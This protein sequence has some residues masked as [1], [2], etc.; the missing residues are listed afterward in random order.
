MHHVRDVDRS[1][2]PLDAAGRT[3]ARLDVL[4][5][6]VGTLHDHAVHD[7]VDA[8][9]RAGR[10]LRAAGDD[11]DLVALLDF[12]LLGHG[13]EHLRRQR[14]DLHVPLHA[15]LAGDRP[16]DTGTDRL[17]LLVDQHGCI[18]V[19]ADGAAVGATDFLGGADDDGAMHVTLLHAAAR[20]GVLHGHHDDITD[21]GR[22]ALRTT[23]HLDALDSAAPRIIVHVETGFH[24]DP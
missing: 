6:L 19:E 8:E 17:L 16:E 18:A 9:H 15:Q 3:A 23:Q 21:L 10:A 12:E 11:D 2:T 13:S 7:A 22:L 14:N 1:F 4:G 24:L 20:N 5:R